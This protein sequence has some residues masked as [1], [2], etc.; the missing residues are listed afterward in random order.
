MF[1]KCQDDS[2]FCSKCRHDKFRDD[3]LHSIEWAQ[4]LQSASTDADTDADTDGGGDK[5]TT[6]ICARGLKCFANMQEDEEISA[7]DERHGAS[8]DDN[9]KNDDDND[10]DNN[11][12][13]NDN[14]NDKDENDR[15]SRSPCPPAKPRAP[16]TVELY[17][18]ERET[19]TFLQPEE[20]GQQRAWCNWCDRL[21]ASKEDCAAVAEGRF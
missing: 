18:D 16:G 2:W 11:N 20:T 12:N 19:E 5:A 14:D 1:C 10:N 4:H 6:I 3:T 15:R 17:I 21:I 9:N 13:D 7:R 8:D